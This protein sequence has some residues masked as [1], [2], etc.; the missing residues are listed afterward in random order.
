MEFTKIYTSIS[1]IVKYFWKC[2]IFIHIVEPEP[3]IDKVYDLPQAEREVKDEITAKVMDG[4]LRSRKNVVARRSFVVW[5]YYLTE[6]LP[7]K[8]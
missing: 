8:Q 3:Y 7:L 5:K 6:V 2:Q 4:S 1:T